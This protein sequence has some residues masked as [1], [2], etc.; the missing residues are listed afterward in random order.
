MFSTIIGSL[1]AL[2]FNDSGVVAGGAASIYAA[3]LVLSLFWSSG[4]GTQGKLVHRL[5]T[6]TSELL[7]LYAPLRL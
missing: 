4:S 7:L 2:L 5:L 6:G 1:A 3:G